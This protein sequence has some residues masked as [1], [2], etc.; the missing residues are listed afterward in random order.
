MPIGVEYLPAPV[1]EAQE[2]EVPVTGAIVPSVMEAADVINV[3][4]PAIYTV[5]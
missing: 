3:E 1:R 4:D 5:I 2:A